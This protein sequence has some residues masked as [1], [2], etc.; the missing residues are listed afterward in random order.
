VAEPAAVAVLRPCRHYPSMALTRRSPRAA[1]R[2]G[3]G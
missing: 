1:P 3:T 2:P